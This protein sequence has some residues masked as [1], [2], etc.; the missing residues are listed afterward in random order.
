MRAEGAFKTPQPPELPPYAK[1][2]VVVIANLV[3]NDEI[4][5]TA[6]KPVP[7][8]GYY[9][10]PN[11]YILVNTT[12][13]QSVFSGNKPVGISPPL[14]R[15]EDARWQQRMLVQRGNQPFLEVTPGD[16]GGAVCRSLRFQSSG[17]IVAGI[18]ALVQN[19]FR[20]AADQL[21]HILLESASHESL[22]CNPNCDPAIYGRGEID[23]DRAMSPLGYLQ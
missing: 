18:A 21:V 8:H 5:T 15:V 7:A 4:T 13:P 9:V 6:D 12:A 23:L 19:K 2:N 10:H 1:K 3:D 22:E 17:D 20:V 16:C 14:M 11:N